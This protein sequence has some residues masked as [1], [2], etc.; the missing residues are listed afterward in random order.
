MRKY[1]TARVVSLLLPILPCVGLSAQTEVFFTGDILFD[2]GVIKAI[3]NRGAESLFDSRIDSL[4]RASSSP[5][6]ELSSVSPS[7]S[8]SK[9]SELS[10]SSARKTFVVGNLECPA[11]E[12]K[13]PLLKQFTFRAD[14]EMLGVL[15]RHGF[16]HLVMA[17]NHTIDQG[18]RGLADTH[19][20]IL[21][22][23][24]TPIGYGRNKREAAEAVKICDYPRPIY[25]LSSLRVMSENYVALDSVP[26]V[27]EA[28]ISS[29]CDSIGSIKSRE[30]NACV[31]IVLHWGA[32][33]VSSPSASQVRDAHRLVDSGADAVIGHH[34][35]TRQKVEE[36]RGK[37]IFYSLGN[38]IFDQTK[39]INTE[40]LIGRLT[41][42]PCSI[43]YEALPMVIKH[44]R[45]ELES[46]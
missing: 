44:C 43:G 18:R 15:K 14:P 33:H 29:L 45:P 37:P 36:Y 1:F 12:I 39:K 34:S 4:F 6:P 24:M 11:T 46:R 32:E 22:A 27:C 21:K 5:T 9:L 30:D 3:E 16:T 41:I 23:G 7:E 25:I 42:F 28:D 17:N 10:L 19:Y 20:N 35:H 38:Y 2:R 8:P 13:A 40:A 26:T 31:I